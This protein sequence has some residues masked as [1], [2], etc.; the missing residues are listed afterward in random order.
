MALRPGGSAA[1]RLPKLE[2][3]APA[4]A[5]PWRARGEGV[6]SAVSIGAV[7]GVASL[8]RS[9]WGRHVEPGSLSL[10]RH[11]WWGLEPEK[12]QS[13]QPNAASSL[14]HAAAGC[15]RWQPMDMKLKPFDFAQAAARAGMPQVAERVR[16]STAAS[17]AAQVAGA[18]FQTSFSAA[19]RQVSN[20]QMEATDTAAAGAARQ[21][22]RQHRTDDGGHAEGPDRLP[23]HAADAQQAGAGLHRHH[24]DA[25]LTGAPPQRTAGGRVRPQASRTACRR[26]GVLDDRRCPTGPTPPTSGG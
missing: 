11:C 10:P 22:D 24:V 16:Q 3:L 19:L 12:R 4:M 7:S 18:S 9:P 1:R 13:S 26:A 14:H 2:S 17:E 21:P 25:G 23:G 8:E 20:A 5:L 15:L 6:A